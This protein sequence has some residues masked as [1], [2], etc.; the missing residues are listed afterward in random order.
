DV[1]NN[2]PIV[3]GTVTGTKINNYT[4][5]NV[6][7]TLTVTPAPLT[8][9]AG[10]TNSIYGDAINPI[11]ATVIGGKNGEVLTATGSTTVTPSFNVGG[12]PTTA[13][14]DTSVKSGNYNVVTV[15]PGTYT[16]TKAGLTATGK[17]AT[18]EYGDNNPGLEVILNGVKLNDDL[19][20]KLNTSA[21]ATANSS[22]GFGNYP[23]IPSVSGD[24]IGNYDVTLVNGNL[25]VGKANATFSTT[26]N[27][28]V[29]TYGDNAPAVSAKI[30]P[31]KNNDGD[32]LGFTFTNLLSNLTL[33]GEYEIGVNVNDPE[34]RLDNYNVVTNLT[35]VNVNKAPLGITAVNKVTTVSGANPNFTAR[36]NGFVNG[37]NESVLSS[38]IVLT[39]DRTNGSPAG[40]YNIFVNG[41]SDNRYT[42][43]KTNGLLTVVKDME[44]PLL[45]SIVMDGTN[46]II[47]GRAF[48]SGRTN[49]VDVILMFTQDVGM[50]LQPLTNYTQTVYP[51]GTN[52]WKD[53][54]VSIP[55]T[56]APM[57]VY[58]IGVNDRINND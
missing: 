54:N 13:T 6:N 12:Y 42:L 49:G 22:S 1:G 23:I 24:K 9:N 29:M 17:D 50:N 47:S 3:P 8:L 57:G 18:R 16:I 34:R 33:P 19:N 5:S 32:R 44:R 30:E 25:N 56:N 38:P 58:K 28:N 27:P 46:A 39:T 11:T 31:L 14:L 48:V 52:E 45:D 37:Q 43:S 15:N 4:V 51:S 35:R 55:A 41:G 40:N 53:F 2:Y 10:S 21:T 36:Y 7:G 26:A 20:G